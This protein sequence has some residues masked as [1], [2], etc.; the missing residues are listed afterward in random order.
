MAMQNIV[1][2]TERI[3]FLD[4]SNSLGLRASIDQ[5]FS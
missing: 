2:E 3:I 5:G 1:H 4:L